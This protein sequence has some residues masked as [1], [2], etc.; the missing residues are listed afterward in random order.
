MVVRV[1]LWVEFGAEAEVAPVL[2]RCSDCVAAL[3]VVDGSAGDAPSKI[4]WSVDADAIATARAYSLRRNRREGGGAGEGGCS[5]AALRGH[6]G[7]YSGCHIVAATAHH[8]V[9]LQ[10]ITEAPVAVVLWRLAAA[11]S[12]GFVHNARAL[13]AQRH[14]ILPV[15]TPAA[16]ARAM[17]VA[18]CEDWTADAAAANCR[19][20]GTG[21]SLEQCQRTCAT[22]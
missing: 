14:E 20:G 16:G 3:G 12:A 2:A 5:S 11:L 4:G 21:G 10:F 15:C 8:V 9:R 6:K 19:G 17:A 22:Y 18:V 13:V 1:P 7:G